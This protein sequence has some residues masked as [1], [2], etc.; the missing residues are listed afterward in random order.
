MSIDL[1]PSELR[2][3]QLQDLQLLQDQLNKDLAAIRYDELL[4]AIDVATLCEQCLH[5]VDRALEANPGGLM[6]ALYRVDIPDH[7]IQ[8]TL[9]GSQVAQTITQLVVLRCWQKVNL[10]KQYS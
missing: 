10:R 8:K 3:V 6:N 1:V 7:I 5:W 2:G 4:Q 9:A